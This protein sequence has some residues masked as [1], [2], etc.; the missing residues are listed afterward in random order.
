MTKEYEHIPW[1]PQ[2]Y[3]HVRYLP[4]MES[5]AYSTEPHEVE[6]MD[7][8]IADI[9]R[10]LDEDTP[11]QYLVYESEEDRTHNIAQ[12]ISINLWG[13]PDYGEDLFL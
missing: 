2:Y 7:D 3:Y 6:N 5:N 11:N 9:Q 13:I 12:K 10:R 8:F 4:S 1:L